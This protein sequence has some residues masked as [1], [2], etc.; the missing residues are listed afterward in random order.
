MKAYSVAT[1]KSL[2]LALLL[3]HA[4]AA[5]AADIKVLGAIGFQ[6][7]MGEAAPRFERATGH[8]IEISTGTIGQLLQRGT[9]P[10]SS[11]VSAVF[12]G[13]A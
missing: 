12:P 9:R 3:G 1:S 11:G 6:P 8:C 7:V 5:Q 2:I 13:I 10:R 4:S